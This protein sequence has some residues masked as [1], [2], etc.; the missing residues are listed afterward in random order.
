MERR[1]IT[2]TRLWKYYSISR[3][4]MDVYDSDRKRYADNSGVHLD[5]ERRLTRLEYLMYFVAVLS[6]LQ[7][8]GIRVID[9]VY[10]FRP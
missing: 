2:F 5:H 6:V 8:A 3:R 10:L 1:L 9:A 4:V 7:F